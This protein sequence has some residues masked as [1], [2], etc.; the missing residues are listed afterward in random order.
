M[1]KDAKPDTWL[2]LGTLDIVTPS[3]LNSALNPCTSTSTNFLCTAGSI[4]LGYNGK[5]GYILYLSRKESTI[6]DDAGNNYMIKI[7]FDGNPP[8]VG[9]YEHNNKGGRE[10]NV[11]A[12]LDNNLS[13]PYDDVN[14][15]TKIGDAQGYCGNL[16][17]CQYTIG[18]YIHKN[19]GMPSVYVK[20]PKN[21]SASTIVFKDI[22]V[23]VLKLH[24]SNRNNDVVTPTS[25][26]LYLSGTISVP[27]RC[28]IKVDENNFDFGTVYSNEKNGSVKD[29]STSITTD[30]YYAPVGTVQ[31][32]KM[33]AVSGGS[34][35]DKKTIYQVGSDSALGVVFNINNYS[36]C[37]PDTID[38]NI[39][40]QEY[41]IRNVLTLQQQQI[42]TDTINFSLCKYG[43]PSITGQK[44]V[45]LKLTSRWVID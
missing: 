25:A 44:T 19:S 6:S 7:A 39:F 13:S 27:Q 38:M 26:R 30:C 14:V 42:S 22:E 1:A 11:T 9:L 45:V 29:V 4:N 5:A 8:V 16:G 40:K 18:S 31:Y 10:W 2:K 41:L 33:E 23:L 24:I 21:I 36:Q 28:Y 34:L 37:E 35:N 3:K 32:L 12:S 43:V 15:A 20:I 17:G